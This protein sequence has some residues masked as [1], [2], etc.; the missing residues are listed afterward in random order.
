MANDG[1]RSA[2]SL[3]PHKGFSCRITR[4]VSACPSYPAAAPWA[5]DLP[6]TRHTLACFKL[7]LISKGLRPNRAGFNVFF[8]GFKLALISKGLRRDT[9]LS[10]DYLLCFKLALI[11]KGLRQH[12][13]ARLAFPQWFQ[14]CP[15]FKGIKTN[16]GAAP[17]ETRRFK[18][19]LISKGLRLP[20]VQQKIN[21]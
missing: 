14:A 20:Q 10:F 15:D 19:A 16:K 12:L 1:V 8:Q 4:V 13:K 9:F 11:S 6:A 7:A 2:D 17:L 3:R 21:R 5:G 18:L